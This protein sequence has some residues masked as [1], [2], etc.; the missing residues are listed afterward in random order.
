MSGA[1]LV[2]GY[3]IVVACWVP[4]LLS[5]LTAGGLSAR[6]GLAAWLA[7]MASVVISAEA[8]VLFLVRAA[9]TAGRGWLRRSAGRLPARSARRPCIAVPRSSWA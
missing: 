6:L 3:A 2:L 1:L 8:A 7:A 4:T 9:I 5:R